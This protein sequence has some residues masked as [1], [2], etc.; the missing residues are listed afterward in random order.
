MSEA[1]LASR[2]IR[3]R[4][5]AFWALPKDSVGKTLLVACLVG[6]IGGMLVTVTTVLL[7]PLHIAN[8]EQEQQQS[9]M[10]VIQRQPGLEGLL[11]TINARQVE[12]RVVELASG[13]Y[14][15]TIDAERYDQHIAAKDAQLSVEIPSELDLANI[16]RRAKHAVVYLV[17][18]DS[19]LKFVLLPIHG[20][21][22]ASTLY[23]YLG[24]NADANTIVGINFHEHSE[25]PGLGARIE[26][27]AW[28]DQWRGK[29][30]YDAQ[31][32]IR[33]GLTRG[34]VTSESPTFDHEI[35]GLTGATMT[36]RGVHHLVRYWLGDHGFGPYLKRLREEN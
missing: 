10:A 15:T 16:R 21:G 12:A 14:T 11:D 7:K 5:R 29:K 17:R 1:D 23:G 2:S 4:Y 6:V 28:R 31:G 20:K 3:Q 36:S 19:K 24:L 35:E 32:E 8:L 30:I 34:P 9:L 25:T 26:N 22:Y 13:R 27:Q 18:Q 33:I